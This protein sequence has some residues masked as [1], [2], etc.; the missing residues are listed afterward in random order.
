MSKGGRHAYAALSV[1]AAGALVLTGCSKGGS[2]YGTK[3]RHKRFRV[4][5][6][7][8]SILILSVQ[9]INYRK[10]EFESTFR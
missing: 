4:T 9:K 5:T 7:V 1:L 3:G 6:N 10:F 8:P 2:D